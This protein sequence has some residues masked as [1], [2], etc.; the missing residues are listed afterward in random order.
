MSSRSLDVRRRQ[1]IIRDPKTGLM[2]KEMHIQQ[3]SQ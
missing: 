3:C 2:K 1:I